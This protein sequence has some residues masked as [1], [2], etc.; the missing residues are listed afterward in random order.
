MRHDEILKLER[1]FNLSYIEFFGPSSGGTFRSDNTPRNSEFVDPT[2]GTHNYRREPGPIAG[3]VAFEEPD[4]SYGSS[5]YFGPHGIAINGWQVVN[6]I[7]P[8]GILFYAQELGTH[9]D[10]PRVIG[11][12][13][14][15]SDGLEIVDFF[16]EGDTSLLN[17]PSEEV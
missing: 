17:F 7:A 2:W 14:F 10:F 11:R 13:T 15:V 16:D 4:V 6:Y 3:R 12:R 9:L 5:V 1:A 8:A